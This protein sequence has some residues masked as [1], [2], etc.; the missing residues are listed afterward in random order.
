MTEP[1]VMR[2]SEEDRAAARTTLEQAR[3][4]EVVPI[5]ILTDEEVTILDGLEHEQLVPTPWLDAQTGADRSLVGRVALRSLL[6]RELVVEAGAPSGGTVAITAH[7]GITGP[8]VLRRSAREIVSVER[9]SS[10]GK[11]WVFAYVHHEGGGAVVLEEEIV[12]A[13][14]HAFS[15]YPL[16]VLGERLEKFLDPTGAAGSGGEARTYDAPSLERQAA[17]LPALSEAVAVSI[18]SGVRRGRDELL[19][20]SVYS[21]PR[22]VHVL[23]GS[24]HGQDGEPVEYSLQEV[25]SRALRAL[26]AEM[27]A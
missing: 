10:S 27:V 12:A 13:G 26:P 22:G 20:A 6:A 23:R 8:L 24:R 9:T 25:D 18:V 2:F 21:G 1:K 14:Q 17:G 7:P 4:G 3:A 19:S 16:E 5:V 15:V 11:H